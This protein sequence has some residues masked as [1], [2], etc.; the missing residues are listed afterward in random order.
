MR[1]VAIL[2]ILGLSSAAKLK[3]E[4]NKESTEKIDHKNATNAS[5]TQNQVGTSGLC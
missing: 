2:C 3:E 5:T 1:L 4:S